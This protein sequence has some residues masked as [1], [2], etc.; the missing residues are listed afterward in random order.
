[1]TS[2]IRAVLEYWTRDFEIDFDWHRDAA[3]EG[4]VPEHWLDPPDIVGDVWAAL[5]AGAT[6]IL[7]VCTS[8]QNRFDI[9]GRIT[10]KLAAAS[11]GRLNVAYSETYLVVARRMLSGHVPDADVASLRDGRKIAL[12]DFPRVRDAEFAGS[13]VFIVMSGPTPRRSTSDLHPR[14]TA[15]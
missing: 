15:Q 8:R 9:A 6:K 13:D 7:V 3:L 1:M 2:D 11:D 12:V 4:P 14:G 10:A 5:N